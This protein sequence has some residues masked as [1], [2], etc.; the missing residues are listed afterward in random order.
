MRAA[1][2]SCTSVLCSVSVLMSCCH[3]DRVSGG[4]AREGCWM[5]PLLIMQ[6]FMMMTVHEM[7][8]IKINTCIFTCNC[9]LANYT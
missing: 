2:V 5:M 6:E 9:V 1:T 4:G 8:F 7:F 3:G